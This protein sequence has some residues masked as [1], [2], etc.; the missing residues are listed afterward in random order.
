MIK[1]SKTLFVYLAICP[2]LT[3][4]QSISQIPDVR[5]KAAFSEEVIA[6]WVEKAPREI[7]LR[8]FFLDH[9]WALINTDNEKKTDD[10]NAIEVP[11]INAINIYQLISLHNLKRDIEYSRYYTLKNSNL[12]LEL[13]SEKK[14]SELFNKASGRKHQ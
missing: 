4:G 13:Y 11:D 12:I 14:T 6:F 10:L 8:N 3:F 9:G 7:E 1:L 5:L 2:F